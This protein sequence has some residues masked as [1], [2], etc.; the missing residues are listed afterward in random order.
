M[1]NSGKVQTGN[2]FG[3][4][5]E[6]P[7]L[8]S[9]PQGFLSLCFPYM[10]SGNLSKQWERIALSRECTYQLAM[11]ENRIWQILLLSS[12]NVKAVSPIPVSA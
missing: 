3:D 6:A 1:T 8:C 2:P 11:A 10:F 5:E 4:L 12:A 9:P 7:S